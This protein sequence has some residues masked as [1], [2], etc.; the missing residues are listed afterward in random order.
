MTEKDS[1]WY[2]CQVN[3]EPKLSNKTY[4]TV[5]GRRRPSGWVTQLQLGAG[6]GGTHSSSSSPSSSTGVM[7]DSP[8]RPLIKDGKAAAA[9]SAANGNNNSPAV[10]STTGEN[11]LFGR[12]LVSWL[13]NPSA[14]WR[15]LSYL[16]C[17]H[18][19]S[20]QVTLMDGLASVLCYPHRSTAPARVIELRL[21][22]H[23]AHNV[24]ARGQD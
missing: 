15:A 13:G 5:L 8:A 10:A 6:G 3:T 7:H 20:P 14:C 12:V 11:S 23:T 4:L 16:A 2:D 1:G 22:T 21:R 19:H 24:S 9:A 18:T 17:I